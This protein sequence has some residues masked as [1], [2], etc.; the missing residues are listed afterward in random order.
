MVKLRLVRARSY[1]SRDKIRCLQGEVID[2]DDS[3]AEYLLNTGLFEKVEDK[4]AGKKT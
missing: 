4:K 1:S 2:V 3:K